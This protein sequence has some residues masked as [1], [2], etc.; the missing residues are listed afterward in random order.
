MSDGQMTGM[1]WKSIGPLPV[2][3]LRNEYSS[4]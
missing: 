2:P 1:G 4:G 3:N